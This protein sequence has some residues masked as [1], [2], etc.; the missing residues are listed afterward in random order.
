MNSFQ[1]NGPNNTYDIFFILG[2]ILMTTTAPPFK[3]N[4]PYLGRMNV[5]IFGILG[6]I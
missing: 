2:A 1:L 6:I 5:A 3:R 4:S